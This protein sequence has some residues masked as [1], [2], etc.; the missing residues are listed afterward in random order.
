VEQLSPLAEAKQIELSETIP[1]K[2]T[3]HGDID[4]LIRL[5]L[6]LLDNAIK[7]TPEGGT[8]SV[9][10]QFE[11]QQASIAITDTGR[12][13]PKEHLPHLFDRFYRVEEDRTRYDRDN[14]Q[15][16]AGL[17]LAIAHEIVR[18]H[19]GE[20]TVVSQRNQGTTFIVHLPKKVDDA[21]K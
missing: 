21:Q 17:G 3:I 7:Y 19:G 16:G 6:N 18:A 1:D 13:I 10:A 20:L 12:G 4:L 2:L 15:S 11:N 9:V 8:V 5:F 14:G